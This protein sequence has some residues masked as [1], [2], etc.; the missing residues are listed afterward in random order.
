MKVTS[1]SQIS[2][3]KL[4]HF[5]KR[6]RLQGCDAVLLSATSRRFGGSQCLHLQ[7]EAVQEH[8]VTGQQQTADI[9]PSESLA[10]QLILSADPG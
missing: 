8:S 9:R 5:I 1:N 6:F 7:G 2:N 3:Q 10:L 4:L